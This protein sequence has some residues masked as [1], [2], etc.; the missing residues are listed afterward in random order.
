MELAGSLFFRLLEVFSDDF[1]GDSG[2]TQ[3]RK[4]LEGEGGFLRGDL[5]LVLNLLNPGP[6]WSSPGRWE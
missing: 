4:I 3:Q 5:K 6:C 2:M 1:F